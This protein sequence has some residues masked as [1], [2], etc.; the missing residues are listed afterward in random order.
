MQL[1]QMKFKQCSK[2]GRTLPEN[3]FH[4]NKKL[5]DG[6]CYWCNDCVNKYNQEHKEERRKYRQEHKEQKN[7]YN[8][9]YRQS[10][11]EERRKYRLLIIEK[12]KESQR[13][14]CQTE[15]GKEV[16]SRLKAKRRR[17]LGFIPF[18]VLG[19]AFIEFDN[20]FHHCNDAI[21]INIPRVIHMN[22]LGVNHR[23]KVADYFSDLGI[24][25]FQELLYSNNS[26]KI[27]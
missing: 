7:I 10:H 16:F 2:C 27:A 18:N 14:Y 5:K 1:I 24:D 12:V 22:N 25:T 15:N 9:K 21:V 3:E 13:K 17:R 19:N 11:K 26:D 6:L 8:K 23:V 4:K 20:D